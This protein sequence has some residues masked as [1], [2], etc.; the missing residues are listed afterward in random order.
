MTSRNT[1]Y[2]NGRFLTQR[3]TGVQRFAREIVRHLDRHVG[4]HP[5][6]ITRDWVLITPPGTL[7][8]LELRHIESRAVGRGRGH[9]WEQTWL[10]HSARDGIL[11]GL[12]NAGP[13][14]HSKQLVVMHDAAVFRLP[15]NYSLSYRLVHRT[16]SHILARRARLVTVS[17]FSR[18]EL[19]DAMHCDP[20]RFDI[21][22]NAVDHCARVASVPSVLRRLGIVENRYFLVVGSNSRN[23]NIRTA[24]QSFLSAGL[25]DHKLVVV[26][27]ITASVFSDSADLS[28]PGVVAAGRVS[29]GEL[30]ALY[31]SATALVFP[32]LYEGFGIPPLEAMASNCP[33]LASD[34]PPVREV[35]GSAAEYFPPLEESALAALLRDRADDPDGREVWQ[36]RGRARAARFTWSASAERLLGLV[37]NMALDAS[38]QAT[39]R[40]VAGV[41]RVET[42]PPTAHR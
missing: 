2:I 8:D 18:A 7:D 20:Q 33:V 31:Q 29:D 19:A 4:N 30:T 32:S 17:Q 22:P 13:I 5:W 39:L 14:I 9:T 6:A 21:V 12:A 16:L 26:G 42:P 23:K 25:S 1:I 27:D 11:V 34:I 37:Q 24:V 3:L 10:A 36:E 35:C 40:K 41:A 15:E 28:G 38:E